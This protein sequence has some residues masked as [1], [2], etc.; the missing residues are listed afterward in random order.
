MPGNDLKLL[1]E[2]NATIFPLSV[3]WVF[4]A[5]DNYMLFS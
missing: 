5:Y 3:T 4:V 1:T 2:K